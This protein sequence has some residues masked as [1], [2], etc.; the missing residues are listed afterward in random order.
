[1]L[2]TVETGTMLWSHFL[3]YSKENVLN[4]KF[5]CHLLYIL[6]LDYASFGIALCCLWSFWL[7]FL[8]IYVFYQ[9]LTHG[10]HVTRN[11]TWLENGQ[12]I[13]IYIFQKYY[14]VYEI[15]LSPCFSHT[16]F[17][18]LQRGLAALLACSIPVEPWGFCPLGWIQYSMG[19]MAS[20]FCC[21][22]ISGN[23]L[24]KSRSPWPINLPSNLV[25]SRHRTLSP[26]NWDS[27]VPSLPESSV[28]KQSDVILICLTL[29]VSYS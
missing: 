23:F 27:V 24:G 1:M 28:A 15:S 9:V 14:L 21:S 19:S 7:S 29:E 10:S 22:T 8:Y 5:F 6:N 25:C 12:S 4:I 13:W 2:F 20:S 26:Q 17:T 18:L 3:C 11:S 16:D